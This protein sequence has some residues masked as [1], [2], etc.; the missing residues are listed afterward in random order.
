M[1]PRK[2]SCTCASSLQRNS[3]C[4]R[5]LEQHVSYSSH[6]TASL[7]PSPRSD[8]TPLAVTMSDDDDDGVD[9]RL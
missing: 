7:P 2:D 5:H 3:T 8:R 4:R 6:S 1:N 9:A